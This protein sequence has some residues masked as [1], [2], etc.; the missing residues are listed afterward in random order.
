MEDDAE[1]NTVITASWIERTGEHGSLHATIGLPTGHESLNVVIPWSEKRFQFTT[2]HQAR[3]SHGELVVGDRRWTFGDTDPSN[4]TGDR[5]D[6]WGV[7]DIGRGRWPYNTRWNWGGGAGRTKDGTV[8]GLQLGGKW[9]VGTGYTENALLV[10][11]RL[12]KIGSE[13]EWDYSWDDPMRPWRVSDPNGQLDVS[14]TPRYDKHDRLDLKVMS[15]ET[16]LVFGTWSGTVTDDNGTRFE[17]TEA[18][19]FAEESRARW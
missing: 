11:G 14:L 17:I 9:T 13:L 8:I 10:N 6:A 7:V 12:S 16:H 5:V 2:K 18:Q 15:R 19:G 1:G 3:P 4:N